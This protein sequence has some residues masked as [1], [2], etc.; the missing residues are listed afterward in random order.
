MPIAQLRM[1]GRRGRPEDRPASIVP[2]ESI[3]GT[4]LI[5]I[6]AIMA[7][8]AS[9][10]VGAV[11]LIRN[12]AA[13]WEGQI[14]REVTIQ[15]RPI[16]GRDVNADV[17]RALELARAVEGVSAAN[18]VSQ[19]EIARLLEPWLGAGLALDELPTPRLIVVEIGSAVAPDLVELDTTLRRDVPSASLDDHRVWLE[20]LRI[21]G[22]TLVAIGL[23][24]LVLILVATVLS[25]FFAT[26]GAMAGNRDVIEVLHVVGARDSFVARAFARR[27]LT[28]GLKGGLI[29]GGAAVLVLATAG[30]FMPDT[31]SDEIG[32]L[33]GRLS[34]DMHGYLG[35]LAVIAFIAAITAA[36]SR[37]TVVAHLRRLD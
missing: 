26:R 3:A 19:A 16:A 30:W 24:V 33:I 21:T 25:V 32:A 34:V 1:P 7:F 18:V 8:L 36:T 17:A 13:G 12:A 15:V 35:I 37:M 22:S 20:R 23:S 11:D 2:R 10:S 5:M 14:V 6:I 31:G 27:F 4:A 9:L 29:G 28:L